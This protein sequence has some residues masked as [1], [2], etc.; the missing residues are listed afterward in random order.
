VL[1]GKG[2]EHV[3]LYSVH[4]LLESRVRAHF[5]RWNGTR[6]CYEAGY[7]AAVTLDSSA[8]RV[9]LGS[10]IIEFLRNNLWNSKFD[11]RRI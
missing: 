10:D 7:A 5:Q 11:C 3:Q 2:W 9:D 8:A 6:A 4:S 1:L